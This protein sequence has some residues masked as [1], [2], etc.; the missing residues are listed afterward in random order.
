V[1]NARA[2]LRLV[3]QTGSFSA[4]LWAFVGHAPLLPTV[5][6]TRENTPVTTPE[7]ETM[8]KALKRADFTFV[9]PTICYAFMQSVGMVDDHVVDCFKYRGLPH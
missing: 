4:W 7:A 6:R 1:Q 8:S 5:P 9:G 2:Y 3:E